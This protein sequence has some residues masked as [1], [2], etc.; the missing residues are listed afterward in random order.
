MARLW[1]VCYDVADDR[2][3]R[4][5]AQWLLGQGDRVLESVFECVWRAEQLP[6]V[7]E[8]LQSLILAKEDALSLTPV[9][10]ACRAEAVA[11]GRHRA[12]RHVSCH[13]V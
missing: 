11:D 8:Q 1:V 9:C 4:R 12:A 10:L 13:I 6:A 5:L 7:R 2:R 3:R